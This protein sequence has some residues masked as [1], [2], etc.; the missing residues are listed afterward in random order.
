MSDTIA[1]QPVAAGT[2]ELE[3]RIAALEAENARLTARAGGAAGAPTGRARPDGGRWRPLVSTLCIVVAAILVPVSIVGAW[4]R[5]EFVNEQSFV[6]TLAPLAEDPQVQGLVISEAMNAIDAKVDFTQLTG[7][8]IDGIAGLGL[9][10]RA[11]AALRLLQKPAADGLHNLVQTGVTNVVQSPAFADVW[12]TA[13]RG[14]HRALVTTATS[15]GNGIFVLTPQGLGLELGPLIEQVKQRLV[16]Q[17]VGVASL[18]PR[19]DKTIIIGDGSAV[20]TIRTVYSIAVTAG[21]WLPVA[22]LALL[23]AGILIARRRSTAVLGAGIALF[24]GGALL[25]SGFSVGTL[26]VANTAS[27]LQLSPSALDVIYTALVDAMHR[28]AL[29]VALLGVLITIIG[30]TTGRWK[31]ARRLRS[32]VGS[33][34]ASARVA[35]DERGLDTGAFGVWIGRQRVLVRS[36]LVVLGVLWLLALRPLSA[37]D[38]L[39]VVIV[40]LLV[41][42]ALELLQKR[43]DDAERAMPHRTR[44]DGADDPAAQG[45]A[46][47][48]DAI[49]DDRPDD[50]DTA[51]IPD[52]DD[53]DTAEIPDAAASAPAKR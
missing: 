1:G 33:L 50:T 49:A 9:G 24:L 51:E 19:I 28:T 39:L 52:A 53:T 34:N 35:L 8:V 17:G 20:I 16:D 41:T 6:A 27:R 14:A 31:P 10:P 30:W 23:L 4:A 40:T 42:W 12:A 11:T 21:W 3:K 13:V 48:D 36:I 32:L 25:A 2:A 18:I 5:S 22:T 43:P 46:I 38:V 44:A 15:D 45:D 26:V 37:G 47:A 7:D 29:I